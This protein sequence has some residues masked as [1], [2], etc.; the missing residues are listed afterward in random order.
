MHRKQ[1][2]ERE[3]RNQTRTD[4]RGCRK[5]TESLENAAK[6]FKQEKLSVVHSRNTSVNASSP[7]TQLQSPG[8]PMSIHT[9][10]E[11]LYRRENKS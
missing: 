2:R 8:A 4:R 11:K 9:S 7:T 6:D 10:T 3:T 5:I 1:I